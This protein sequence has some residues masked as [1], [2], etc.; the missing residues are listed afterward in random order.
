MK[1][2]SLA[3]RIAWLVIPTLM[4]LSGISCITYGFFEMLC[5]PNNNYPS[6]VFLIGCYLIIGTIFSYTISVVIQ[7]FAN[8]DNNTK[9]I[10]KR[11]ESIDKHICKIGQYQCDVLHDIHYN[12]S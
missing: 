2:L 3:V 4:L 11:L 9:Q 8:I 1:I 5:G 12:I 10:Q 6:I 7:H